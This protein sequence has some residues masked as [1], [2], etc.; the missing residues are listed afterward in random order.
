MATSGHFK[1]ANP[2]G[3]KRLQFWLRNAEREQVGGAVWPPSRCCGKTRFV[4]T[5][6]LVMVTGS[7]ISSLRA[8][9]QW[10]R[11]AAAAT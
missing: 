1:W 8:A 4:V 10:K 11:K 3:V 5:A 9:L 6:E 7:I 2:S